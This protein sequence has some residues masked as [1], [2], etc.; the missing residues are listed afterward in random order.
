MKGVSFAD[1]TVSF[2]DKSGGEVKVCYDLLVAADGANSAVRDSLEA[3]DP[4][5]KVN[6]VTSFRSYKSIR[7]LKLPSQK[8]QSSI[9]SS[10]HTLLLF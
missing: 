2:V 4:D 3:Y 1:Q 6:K 8:S 9:Q 7:S 5:F 10:L